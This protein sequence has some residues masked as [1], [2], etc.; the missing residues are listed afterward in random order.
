LD[1]KPTTVDAKAIFDQKYAEEISKV[2]KPTILVCG[3]CGAGK[4]S[5]IQAILGKDTVPDERIG[6][7]KPMTQEFVQYRNPFINLWDSKGLEPGDREAEFLKNTKGLVS[8][9]QAD[10]DARNH[11]H[12]V[13]YTIQGPGARVTGTDK[14]LIR[15]V[16]SNVIV[17]ITK[18]DS[19]RSNQREAITKE[20]IGCGVAPENIV[21][22][23]ENDHES[24]RKLVALSM[25]LLPAAYRDAF[26]SAQMIDLGSKRAKAQVLIHGAA[27]SAAAAGA[28]PIPFADA[29]IITP[30]QFTM[31]AGLAVVYGLPAEW[32]KAAAAPI[33]AE[34][35]GVM[36]ASSL[37]KLLPGFGSVIQA[38]VAFAL[39]EVIGQLV[40]G[41]M[42]HC[43]EARIKGQPMPDFHLPATDLAQMLI[44]H[45]GK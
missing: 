11:I 31:I 16:F 2:V 17:V 26:R 41:W 15:K 30:I 19:T 18:N 42:F 5:L 12:L 45:K 1:K 28:I 44:A 38:G 4:T 3:Y 29:F 14:E 6:H 27:T 35:A 25:R 8:R 24:L 43:C 7:G 33:V 10:P 23:S 36:A 37:T 40:D 39:T 9:L 21:P 34:T 20:L 32:A 13:W 22:V